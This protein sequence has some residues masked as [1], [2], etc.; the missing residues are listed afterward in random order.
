LSATIV[1]RLH[2]LQVKWI[3]A[4]GSAAPFDGAKIAGRQDGRL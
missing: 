1:S 2:K 3:L 4:G